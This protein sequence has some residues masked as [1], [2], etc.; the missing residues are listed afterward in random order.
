ME[1]DGLGSSGVR[2]EPVDAAI[3]RTLFRGGLQIDDDFAGNSDYQL[4]LEGR[5]TSLTEKGG[6]WRTLVGLGR[7]LSLS[8]DLYLPFAQRGNWLVSPSVEYS[9]LNQPLVADGDTIAQYRLSTYGGA[10]KIGRDFGD[11]LQLS[12]SLV[13]SRAQADLKIGIPE[14][15]ERRR[16]RRLVPAERSARPSL[17]SSDR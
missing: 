12:T 2:V 14:L 6:E 1:D 15:E 8:T 3:G 17:P 5:I 10:F 16:H 9:S 13:R 11:K 4:N 7:V